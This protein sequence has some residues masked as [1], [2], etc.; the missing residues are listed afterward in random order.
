VG[1]EPKISHRL[2]AR[3]ALQRV[4]AALGK[5]PRLED[6]RPIDE[7]LLKTGATVLLGTFR[8]A[9]H[10]F[11]DLEE[12]RLVLGCLLPLSA[13]SSSKRTLE[14]RL[15]QLPKRGLA[16]GAPLRMTISD[17]SLDTWV[18]AT[19]ELVSSEAGAEAALGEL[20]TGAGEAF[21]VLSTVRR[22]RRG[23]APLHAEHQLSLPLSDPD[24]DGQLTLPILTKLD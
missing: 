19:L 10:G 17:K 15:K 2:L 13:Q 11:V 18:A 23:A 12:G 20:L 6:V 14:R 9:L 3:V 24:S 7:R 4:H 16:D 8:H 1:S 21:A 22:V 5:D